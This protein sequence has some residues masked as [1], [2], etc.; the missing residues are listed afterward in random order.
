MSKDNEF[1]RTIPRRGSQEDVDELAEKF[2]AEV[3]AMEADQVVKSPAEYAQ[4][5]TSEEAAPEPEV[6]ETETVRDGI[7]EALD[8]VSI[9]ELYAELFPN[10]IEAEEPKEKKDPAE[11]PQD[12]I[13]ADEISEAA[14]SEEP[15]AD[16]GEE[17]A[18]D[19]YADAMQSEDYA[20]TMQSEDYA[21]AVQNE[22]YAEAVQSE[23]SQT[24]YGEENVTDSYAEAAQDDEAQTVKLDN[25]YPGEELKA[26]TYV[27]AVPVPEEEPEEDVS[28]EQYMEAGTLPFTISTADADGVSVTIIEKGTRLPALAKMSFSAPYKTPSAVKFRL[29]MGEGLYAKDNILLDYIK[30]SGIK[31]YNK[32]IT[33]IVLSLKVE[34]NGDTIIE[35]LDEGSVSR[36]KD[37]IELDF[38]EC[39]KAL[40]EKPSKITSEDAERRDNY[41]IIQKAR[42]T[43]A[44]AER[45][46]RINKKDIDKEK[47]RELRAKMKELKQFYKKADVEKLTA[48]QKASAQNLMKE[49]I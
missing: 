16:S 25:S 12:V 29:Y 43:Y 8:D 23:E 37:K 24:E 40:R 47:Q 13:G 22:D 39:I 9:D 48:A 49:F 36:K 11:E 35:L 7:D 44:A 32:G 21:E 2:L 17:T 27:G 33:R 31:T 4:E 19:D 38:A 45:Y 18:S 34:K 1:G 14:V 26:E 5:K 6:S 10:G 41:L 15:Q 20:N 42:Y 3:E 28:A 30:L 46:L